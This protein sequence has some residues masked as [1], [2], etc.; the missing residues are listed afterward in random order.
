[1]GGGEAAMRTR[2]S[3]HVFVLEPGLAPGQPRGVVR[4]VV[5]SVTT[6]KPGA[7]DRLARAAAAKAWPRFHAVEMPANVGT[8]V[9]AQDRPAS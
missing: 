7:V 6:D 1:M 3:G 8:E 2:Y 5:V 4:D 9:I